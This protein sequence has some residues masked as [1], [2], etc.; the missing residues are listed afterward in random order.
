MRLLAPSRPAGQA[1][2]ALYKEVLAGVRAGRR[3]AIEEAT[4]FLVADPWCFRSGYLKAELMHALANTPLPSDVIQPLREVVLR[5]ITDRQ[6]RLLRYATQ[7][8]S[9]VWDRELEA[10]V[11][12]LETEGSPEQRR[13]AAQVRVGACHRI[14]SLTYER[15]RP[16]GE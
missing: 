6:P 14:R 4:R 3:D 1:F 7:L 16:A 13:A 9:H 15:S 2:Y 8:A 11:A 5:R 10:Q 12:H